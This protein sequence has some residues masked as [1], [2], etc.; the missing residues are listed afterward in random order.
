M[1]ECQMKLTIRPV[2]ESFTLYMASLWEKTAKKIL[3]ELVG[4]QIAIYAFILAV[5]V[6]CLIL[7]LT[8]KGIV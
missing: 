5:C 6:L 7:I 8:Y 1:G 2:D 3:K 4:I